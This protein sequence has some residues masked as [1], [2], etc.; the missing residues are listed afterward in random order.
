MAA[1][2]KLP[3]MLMRLRLWAVVVSLVVAGALACESGEILEITNGT[4]EVISIGIGDDRRFPVEPGESY[5]VFVMLHTGA[6]FLVED[7]H[8]VQT[9]YGFR[10]DQ[11]E[12]M[13]FR[14]TIE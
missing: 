10:W 7:S 1:R 6:W 8:G 3:L 11:M 9:E 12:R 5:G 4:E 14:F 2:T 13:E